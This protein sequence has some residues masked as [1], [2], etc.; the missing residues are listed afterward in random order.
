[1][2]VLSAGVAEAGIPELI[3]ELA[4][5]AEGS[6]V[7]ADTAT[8]MPAAATYTAV[9]RRRSGRRNLPFVTSVLPDLRRIHRIRPP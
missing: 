9:L 1:M 3:P 6:V 7:R 8:A 5:P 4:A 2:A